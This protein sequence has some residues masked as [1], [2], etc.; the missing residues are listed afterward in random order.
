MTFSNFAETE[1]RKLYRMC[2]QEPISSHK[3]ESEGP[4]F[5]VT[6]KSNHIY[7]GHGFDAFYQF[8][9]AWF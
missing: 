3:I 2:G 4:F 7:D 1:D 5:R 9:G 6:F 8:L